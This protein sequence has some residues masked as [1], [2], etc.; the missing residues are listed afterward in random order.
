M[1][2]RRGVIFYTVAGYFFSLRDIGSGEDEPDGEPDCSDRFY[3][4]CIRATVDGIKSRDKPAPYE[5]CPE[6]RDKPAPY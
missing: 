6:S 4:A 3:T 2:K 5:G 1:N